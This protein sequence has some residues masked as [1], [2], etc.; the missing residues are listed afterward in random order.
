MYAHVLSPN[1][2]PWLSITCMHPMNLCNATATRCARSGCASAMRIAPSR[3]GYLQR[4]Q[5][6]WLATDGYAQLHRGESRRGLVVFTS[7]P[8]QP[9]EPWVSR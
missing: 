9:S 1:A 2:P 6:T 7:G 5:H 3:N 8:S 4:C